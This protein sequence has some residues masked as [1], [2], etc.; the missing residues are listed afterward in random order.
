MTEEGPPTPL[1]VTFIGSYPAEGCGVSKYTFELAKAMRVQGVEVHTRKVDFWRDGWRYFGEA[2]RVSLDILRS[3]SVVHLQ[4]TPTSIGPLMALLPLLSRI[5]SARLIITAHEKPDVYIRHMPSILGAMFLRME[6]RLLRSSFAV[7]VHTSEHADLLKDR[8]G[9]DNILVVP[10]P[11]GEAIGDG[12]GGEF[13]K[14]HGIAGKAITFFGSIRPNKGVEVLIK[15]FARIRSE[16]V[17]VIAGGVSKGSETYADLLEGLVASTGLGGR[18]VCPGFIN[19][20]DIPSLMGASDLI[21]LPYVESTQ[22]GVLLREVVPYRRPAIVSD[23]GG[24]GEAAR[25]YGLAASFPSGDVDSLAHEIDRL[26]G[27]PSALEEIR[28]RQDAYAEENSAERVASRHIA[29]YS[30]PSGDRSRGGGR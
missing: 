13:K 1:R 6:G 22:S 5:T 16:A 12:D 27:D 7:L 8:Y 10:H 26:L 28:R 24:L 14:A 23:V 17:L 19:D 20:D 25:E 2:A 18:V 9:L 21:V 15:A 11:S 3:R 29:I 30:E 4:Y